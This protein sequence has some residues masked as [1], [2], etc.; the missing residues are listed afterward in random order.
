MK[1]DISYVCAVLEV[2][3]EFYKKNY[4]EAVKKKN[5]DIEIVKKTYIANTPIYSKKLIEVDK[6]FSKI[7]S[8]LQKDF[9]KTG[10]DAI[11]GLRDYEMQRVQT[12]D[13]AKLNKIKA[14]KDIPMSESELLALT[15]KFSVK[16]DYWSSRLIQSIADSNSISGIEVE[17]SLDTKM[18]VLDQLENQLNE[19]I[20]Y[21]PCD[22][23]PIK[24][25]MVRFGY[26]TEKILQNAKE[27][28]GGKMRYESDETLANRAYLT[29]L[30]KHGDIEKGF[31]I[32]NTLKNAKGEIRNLL[33]CRLAKEKRNISDFAVELSGNK[34]EIDSF[35]NGKAREY[36]HARTAVE[37]MLKATEEETIHRIWEENSENEFMEQLVKEAGK[38]NEHFQE[39]VDSKTDKK[40]A[41]DYYFQIYKAAL[42]KKS[43]NQTK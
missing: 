22:N 5:E 9:A 7:I 37:R 38:K 31:A 2:E 27:I 18:S 12:V 15:Q 34:E 3:A 39:V 11:Q 28:Y 24:R 41:E 30:S 20:K 26:L 33:L 36:L 35:R 13:E 23:D 14:V 17:S 1:T 8:Q 19:I 10:I 25:P 32:Q 21:Y 29:I 42:D 4:D 43:G 40:T 16:N 6:D